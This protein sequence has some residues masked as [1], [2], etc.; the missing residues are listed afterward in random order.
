M[1]LDNRTRDILL[2]GEALNTDPGR[3]AIKEYFE[4]TGGVL[5]DIDGGVKVGYPN[6][7]MAEKVS[8]IS[9]HD[10]WQ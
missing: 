5:E 6:R 2:S 1:R 10:S 7:E 3:H 8:R 4:S 9:H